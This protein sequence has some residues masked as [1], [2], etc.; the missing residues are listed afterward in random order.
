MDAK[1]AQSAI[2][3]RKTQGREERRDYIRIRTVLP[4]MVSGENGSRPHE[5]TTTDLS[6]AGV[7]IRTHHPVTEDESLKVSIAFGSKPVSY[8]ARVVFVEQLGGGEFR[9]GLEFQNMS[10]GKRRPLRKCIMRTA[11]ET[12]SFLFDRSL[13]KMISHLNAALVNMKLFP[14]SHPHTAASIQRSY[15]ALTQILEQRG[16]LSLGIVDGTLIVDRLPLGKDHTRYN[17]VIEE[18]E[19][20]DICTLVFRVGISQEEFRVFVDC[21]SQKPE[22][23]MAEGGAQTFLE[24]HGVS[25]LLARGFA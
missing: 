7:A 1:P 8:D 19:T 3:D 12:R 23:L 6:M 22:R 5:G 20:K 16:E 24:S 17:K 11:L 10:E 18:L 2:Q 9:A 15:D 21:L 4:I 14:K 13:W 25:H